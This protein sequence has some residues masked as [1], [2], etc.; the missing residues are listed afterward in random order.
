M[1]HIVTSYPI[2][3]GAY[4]A[5]IQACSNE[6]QLVQFPSVT[7]FFFVDD[8]CVCELKSMALIP[9]VQGSKEN[10]WT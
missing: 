2:A 9:G 8:F 7:V 10:T 6:F 1:L 3:E 4:G 5:H